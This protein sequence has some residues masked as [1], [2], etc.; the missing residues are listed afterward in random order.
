MDATHCAVRHPA[1]LS[2]S[3][4]LPL[5]MGRMSCSLVME[6]IGVNRCHRIPRA[7]AE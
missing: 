5:G 6:S 7:T 4:L 3:S 1:S 2:L